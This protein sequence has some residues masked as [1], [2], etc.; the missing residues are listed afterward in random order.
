MLQV[1][2]SLVLVVGAGLLA[3]TFAGLATRD[4][5]FDRRGV[6]LV[7]A[8]VDQN[9]LE[10]P[11]RLAL[12]ERFARAAA[13]VPGVSAAAACFT[14]PTASAGWNT[15]IAVPAGSS[16]TRR[17]RM[18]ERSPVFTAAIDGL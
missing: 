7:T 8:R 18:R 10:E 1:A 16:L 11:A 14:T 4:A 15:M 9:P 5:G 13:A 2:L 6:L 12:F 3:R 17:Q